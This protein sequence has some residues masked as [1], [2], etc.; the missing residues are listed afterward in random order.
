MYNKVKTKLNIIFLSYI[1]DTDSCWPTNPCKEDTR[2]LPTHL[3]GHACL[4]FVTPC[5][6]SPCKHGYCNITNDGYKCTCDAGCSGGSCE[7]TPCTASPCIHGYCK[8]TNDGYKCTCDAG[9]SGVNCEILENPC[10]PDPCRFGR[11]CIVCEGN[12]YRCSANLGVIC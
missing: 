1:Q 11:N 12:S 6:A 2:C 5:T 4:T 3:N 9:Y 10:M 7:I 8:M